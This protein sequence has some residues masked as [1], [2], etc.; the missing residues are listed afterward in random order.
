MQF[1]TLILVAIL[2]EGIITYVKPFF[3]NGKFQWQM[4]VGLGLGIAVAL[5]YN[6]DV[7]AMLKIGTAIPYIGAILTGILLSRGSNYIFDLVKALQGASS[8][9]TNA[10][11]KASEPL[12]G[13]VEQIAEGVEQAADKAVADNTAPNP[14]TDGATVK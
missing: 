14:P 3:V 6:V 11:I 12:I 5:I 7:F 2:I 9:T 1:L 13:T 10:I 8:N 4:L